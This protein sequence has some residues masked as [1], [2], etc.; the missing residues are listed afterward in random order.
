M[1]LED[2]LVDEPEP[3]E[4]LCGADAARHPKVATGPPFNGGDRG[5]QVVVAAGDDQ[6]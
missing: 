3:G 4:P 5:N 1:D 6:L 2:V